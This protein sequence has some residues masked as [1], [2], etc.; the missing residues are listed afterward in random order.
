MLIYLHP[1]K[2]FDLYS[3]ACNIQIGAVL[4]QEGLTVG[5]F[6]CER[7]EVQ[8]FYQESGIDISKNYNTGMLKIRKIGNW[9]SS[10]FGSE[11]GLF[12]SCTNPCWVTFV[13]LCVDVASRRLALGLQQ[14][15]YVRTR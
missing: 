2:S 5:C 3:D 13:Y 10:Y 9:T 12:Q 7:N 11:L 6:S 15:T 14:C 1:D 4:C 8:K